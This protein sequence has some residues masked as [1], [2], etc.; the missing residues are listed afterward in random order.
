M[1]SQQNIKI[2]ETCRKYAKTVCLCIDPDL[3]SQ[4][5]LHLTDSV[6][7]SPVVGRRNSVRSSC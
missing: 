5:N 1:H 3:K 6:V 7:K 2:T 4:D